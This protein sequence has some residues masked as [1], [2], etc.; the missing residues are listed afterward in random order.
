MPIGAAQDMMV[1]GFDTLAIMQ[2]GGLK[3]AN[4]VFRYVENAST[5]YTRGDGRGHAADTLTL[6]LCQ[7]PPYAVDDI[8]LLIGG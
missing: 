5:R 4:V 8:V 1:S 6:T 7:S 2:A 3:S